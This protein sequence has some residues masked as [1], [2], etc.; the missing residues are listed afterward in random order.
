MAP[1]VV[2]VPAGVDPVELLR[3]YEPVIRFTEGELFFPMAVDAYVEQ[4]ALWGRAAG[5]GERKRLVDH[6]ELDLDVLCTHARTD[7]GTTLE[8]HY[9][10]AALTPGRVT[11]VAARSQPPTFPEHVAVCRGRAARQDH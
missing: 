6:G 9:V 5:K 3:R 8:L 4:A 10:P 11:A 2:P 7:V 1:N